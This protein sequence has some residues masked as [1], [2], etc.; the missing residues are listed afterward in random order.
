MRRNGRM[1]ASPMTAPARRSAASNTAS[2]PLASARPA[3]STMTG[4][5]LAAARSALMNSRAGPTSSIYSTMLS[6]RESLAR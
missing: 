3:L 4:L 6:V 1:P 2:A 5:T